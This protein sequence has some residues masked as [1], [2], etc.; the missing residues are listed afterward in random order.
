MTSRSSSPVAARRNPRAKAVFP[1]PKSPSNRMVVAM[2]DDDVELC[3]CNTIAENKAPTSS[4]S[5]AVGIS[6][7]IV[8]VVASLLLLLFSDEKNLLPLLK[9][10]LLRLEFA[11]VKKAKELVVCLG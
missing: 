11:V 10:Q 3:C 5:S 9:L 6:N 7:W 4:V 1:A 8:F 2:G